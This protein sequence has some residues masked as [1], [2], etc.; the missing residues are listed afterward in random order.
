MSTSRIGRKPV[1]IPSGVEVKIQDQ[2]LSVKGPKGHQSVELHPFVHVMIENNEIKV[3]PN[4]DTEQT[5]T[6]QSIK[7]YRSIAGTIRSCHI[8]DAKAQRTHAR[9]PGIVAKAEVF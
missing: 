2:K 1:V 7:L 4:G 3:Q 5:L 9:W 8:S 6:G